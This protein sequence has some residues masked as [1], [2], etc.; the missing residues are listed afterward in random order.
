MI[1]KSKVVVI[2]GV[3]PGMGRKLAI[4][5][6][7]EGAKLAL[8]ARSRATVEELVPT[9]RAAGG[10]AVALCADVSK[11]EDCQRAIASTVEAFGRVDG[12]VNSA[13]GMSPMVSIEEADLDRWRA[14]MDVTLFGALNMVKAALPAMKETGGGAIVNIGT[15]ETRKPLMNNGAY[16]VP[17][18]ALQAATRQMATEFGKYHIRVNSAVIGWMWGKPVEQHMKAFSAQSGIPLDK[19]I[20][21]RASHIPIGHIPPDEECAKSVLLLLSDYTSQVT[22]AAWDINGGELY[23]Q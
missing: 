8:V 13:Y 3:G 10:E 15:M 17:K 2:T 1:L 12:L 16:N 22:G 5:A 6:A 14:C 11:P 21:E 18:A 7:K 23:S 19:L 4:E 9:I 20:E